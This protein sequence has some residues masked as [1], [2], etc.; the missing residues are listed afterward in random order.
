MWNASNAAGPTDDAF[1][2]LSWFG[3][4]GSPAALPC[5]PMGNGNVGT[6]PAS[7]SISGMFYEQMVAGQSKLFP[8]AAQ[9]FNGTG[10]DAP[11]S[12]WGPGFVPPSL[13]GISSF[14]YGGSGYCAS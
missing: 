9:L 14:H 4:I 8:A 5:I 1:T 6:N 11:S 7:A 3:E 2:G 12:P 10:T 13:D